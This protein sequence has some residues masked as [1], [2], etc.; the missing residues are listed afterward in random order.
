MPS[1]SRELNWIATDLDGTLFSREWENPGSIPGTWR[2]P[3]GRVSDQ[4]R[5]PSSWTPLPI[6]RLYCA[7]SE[8]ATI[9]PVTARDYEAYSRV[10]VSRL[11]LSALA[12]LANGSL[13]LGRNGEVD[14]N[15]HE[16]IMTRINDSRDAIAEFQSWIAS[17]GGPELRSRIVLGGHGQPGFVLAKADVEWWSS[18]RGIRVRNGCSQFPSLSISLAN[19]EL[20]AIPQGVSKELAVDY[21][22]DAYFEGETP[23]LCLGD[24][25]ED[26][27]FMARGTMMATPTC[28]SIHNAVRNRPQS[29]K[30]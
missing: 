1:Q 20:Q 16:I 2:A 3:S 14:E 28:S 30:L 4:E 8:I 27:P 29:R 19:N 7:L 23:L 26:L 17:E 25:L 12:V 11:E 13:I 9:V 6:H 21:L 15:W 10:E 22:C 24:R 18:D 5:I